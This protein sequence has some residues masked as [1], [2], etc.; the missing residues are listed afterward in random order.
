MTNQEM[1]EMLRE[2]EHHLFYASVHN[3][4]NEDLQVAYAAARQA[5]VSFAKATGC[6][7]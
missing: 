4:E 5:L 7:N 1:F 6:H 3:P 2:I